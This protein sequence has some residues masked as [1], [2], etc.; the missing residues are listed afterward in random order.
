[1]AKKAPEP[2][3]WF[4]IGI[5]RLLVSNYICVHVCV[6]VIYYCILG[7]CV[8]LIDFAVNFCGPYQCKWLPTGPSSKWPI[9][10]RVRCWTLL[11]NSTIQYSLEL[12]KPK[13]HYADFHRNF[14]AG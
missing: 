9:L 3:F 6:W 12:L 10:R 2:G 5:V 8:G 1:M 4:C 13:F 14:P 7:F 11:T